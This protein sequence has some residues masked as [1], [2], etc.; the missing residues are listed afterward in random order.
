VR[1]EAIRLGPDATRCAIVLPS[2]VEAVTYRGLYHEYRF[3]L[4]DGQAVA[5]VTTEPQPLGEGDA[6]EI[7]VAAEDLVPLEED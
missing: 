4:A 2:R 6:A 7:G 1:G 5:A 3:R